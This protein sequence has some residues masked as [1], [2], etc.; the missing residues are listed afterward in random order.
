MTSRRVQKA[1]E[2]IREV[3]GM[4]ILRDL[5][6]P[7]VRNVTVTFVEVSPDLRQAKVHVSIMGSESEQRLCLHGLNNAAGFLQAKVAANIEMRYTPRLHFVI[8][9]GVKRSIE[10]MRIL[11]QLRPAEA[12]DAVEA[13]P[14]HA[15]LDDASLEEDEIGEAQ[16][17]EPDEDAA[18]PEQFVGDREIKRTA[19]SPPSPADAPGPR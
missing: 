3:V 11:Q 10:V 18:G 16:S 17:D 15:Q 14:D 5:R 6:D 13:E 9:Q 2:A 7:R 1:A 4:A 12:A 19:E 8:D